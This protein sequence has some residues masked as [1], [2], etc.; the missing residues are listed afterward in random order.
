MGGSLGVSLHVNT[1]L[2][3]AVFETLWVSDDALRAGERV[4]AARRDEA[5]RRAAGTLTAEEFAVPVFEQ[6]APAGPAP[7]SG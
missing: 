7:A 5:V 2:G 3:I 6:E 1:D 4:I